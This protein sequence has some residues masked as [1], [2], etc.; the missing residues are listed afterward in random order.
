VRFNPAGS[1]GE[2][3]PCDAQQ[4]I[5]AGASAAASSAIRTAGADPCAAA[6]LVVESVAIRAT[7]DGAGL[8]LIVQLLRGKA[9]KGRE[10]LWPVALR[11]LDDVPRH[12]SGGWCWRRR[13]VSWDGHKDPHSTRKHLPDHGTSN[14]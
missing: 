6:I 7:T 4:Q 13:C 8:V 11:G 3:P 1:G 10:D 2:V 14:A 12:V 9:A 5:H